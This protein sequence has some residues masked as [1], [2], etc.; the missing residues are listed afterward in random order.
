MNRSMK[1]GTVTARGIAIWY[2]KGQ[3]ISFPSDSFAAIGKGMMPVF[4]FLVVAAIFH[5]ALKYTRY[6]K[7]T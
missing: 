7:F 5:V 4:I 2:T 1:A 6:G 3:P